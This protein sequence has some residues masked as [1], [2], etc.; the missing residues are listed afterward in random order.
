MPVVPSAEVLAT[1][2]V[3]QATELFASLD[4]ATLTDDQVAE[5]VTAVQQ[6]PAEVRQAFEEQ[7]DIFSGATDS[8]VP[9]GSTVPVSTRRTLIVVTTVAMVAAVTTRRKW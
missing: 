2:T 4:V 3:E 5:L 7:I 6:A 9:L 8:Y 1:A